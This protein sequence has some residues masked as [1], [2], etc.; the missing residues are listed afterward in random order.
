MA[1]VPGLTQW[2]TRMN[3]GKLVPLLVALVLVLLPVGAIAGGN[4]GDVATDFTLWDETGTYH[5]LYDYWG[6]IIVLN[7]GA[8]W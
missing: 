1:G 2:R 7:F 8:L 4:V 6:Q 5:S 3:L